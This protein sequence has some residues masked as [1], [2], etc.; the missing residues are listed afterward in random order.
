MRNSKVEI[1]ENY[2][3]DCGEIVTPL[4]KTNDGLFYCEIETVDE[5]GNTETKRTTYLTKH[6]ILNRQI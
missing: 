6:D 2:F 3:N 1:G 5:N 4:F